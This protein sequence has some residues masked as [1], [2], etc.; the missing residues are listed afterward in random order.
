ML[1]SPLQVPRLPPRVSSSV[2]LL[3]DEEVEGLVELVV[4]VLRLHLLGDEVEHDAVDAEVQLLH[5]L[6]AV[7]GA[8]LGALQAVGQRADLGYNSVDI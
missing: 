4:D 2:P 5:R 6:L 3:V 8:R 7:L 1:F